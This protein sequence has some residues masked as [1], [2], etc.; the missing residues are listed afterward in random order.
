MNAYQGAEAIASDAI[1][2]DAVAFATNEERKKNAFNE[3][4]LALIPREIQANTHMHKHTHAST[5]SHEHA[6]ELTRTS[7]HTRKH[8]LKHK[9]STHAK[10]LSNEPMV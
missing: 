7:A 10:A 6:Q 3:N 1:A 9:H 4:E 2:D 5:N 8:K